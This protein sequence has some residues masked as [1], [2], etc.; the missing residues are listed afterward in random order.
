V[1]R[2]LKSAPS[3][4]GWEPKWLSSTVVVYRREFPAAV[5]L[6]TYRQRTSIDDVSKRV[7]NS[8]GVYYVSDKTSGMVSLEW[9]DDPFEWAESEFGK[10]EVQ[11]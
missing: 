8:E 11:S 4:K 9:K 3:V 1:R 6:L 2:N 10:R 5:V 7:W